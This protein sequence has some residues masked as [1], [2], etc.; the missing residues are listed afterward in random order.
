MAAYVGLSNVVSLLVLM[1]V[2]LLSAAD[3]DDD[4]DDDDDDG[5]RMQVCMVVSIYVCLYASFQVEVVDFLRD[6]SSH[7]QIVG[8]KFLSF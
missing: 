8:L 5:A 4:D 2:L 1:L 3:G 7:L 6:V